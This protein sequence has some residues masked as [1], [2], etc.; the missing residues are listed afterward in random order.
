MMRKV[1][2]YLFSERVVRGLLHEVLV[3]ET[4]TINTGVDRQRKRER[5]ERER[6]RE[7]E[8]EKERETIIDLTR[9]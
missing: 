2:T 4:E 3:A 7:R 8:R 6:E 9:D 5:Q 1:G